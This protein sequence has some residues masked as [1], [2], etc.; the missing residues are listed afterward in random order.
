VSNAYRV[1][2]W[3]PS[4][5]K[6]DRIVIASIVAYLV[7]F[8]AVSKVVFTG[9]HAVS[10]PILILRALGSCAALLL[11]FILCI[12]PLARLDRRFL[13]LLFNRR[14]LGVATF[15]VSLLHGLLVL[16]W[17]HGFGVVN[18][19]ESLLSSN[20]QLGSLTAFPFEILGV[21]A[22]LILFLMAATS[23]D[24]WLHNLS[25]TTWKRLHMLVYVAWAMVV[26]HMA[27]GV[28]QAERG[29]I[30]A[31][32]AGVSVIVVPLLHLVA[33]RRE[34]ARD[35]AGITVRADQEWVD[36]CGVDDVK[37]GRG[38]SVC[39]AGAERIAV[40]RHEGKFS[41]MSNVCV[42]QGG[43]L[44]EGRIIKGCVTCPWHGY[45][46]LPHNGQSPPPFSEKV[47]TFRVKVRDGRILVNPVPLEPGTE[48]E[49][50]AME[51][52]SRG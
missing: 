49:P 44:G 7:L 4:K 23:H 32:F 29:P 1:V 50:A 28:V 33:G 34:V 42:H 37:E 9:D 26:G 38:K 22:L 24:F 18:P 48:V 6:Y 39:I 47:A 10:D 27:L 51:E 20:T 2:N 30:Y 3:T 46:Y 13:P 21:G 15:F 19:F 14:H 40:F 45:Q 5:R 16:G 25:A 52:V 11:T 35:G 43:P 31:V 36:V 17:Y 8:I 12:G 41:A